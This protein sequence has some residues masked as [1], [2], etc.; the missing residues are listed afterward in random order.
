M[1]H[2]TLICVQHVSLT[3][4]CLCLD[5]E[6]KNI[7]LKADDFTFSTKTEWNF[8]GLIRCVC[9][10]VCVWMPVCEYVLGDTDEDMMGEALT[11]KC[12]FTGGR[13]R[14]SCAGSLANK[15]PV[16][17]QGNEAGLDREVVEMLVSVAS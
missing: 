2:E 13:L 4:I 9:L 5:S 3:L 7:S 8:S 17:P 11:P 16:I 6:D 1:D 12:L 15:Y 14:A 10:S